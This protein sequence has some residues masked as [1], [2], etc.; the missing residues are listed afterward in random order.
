MFFYWQLH[1]TINSA[2]AWKQ[3]SKVSS[4]NSDLVGAG[5]LETM[6]MVSSCSTACTYSDLCLEARRIWSW[7]EIPYG[8]CLHWVAW[9][10]FHPAVFLIAETCGNSHANPYVWQKTIE[11]RQNPL[12]VPLMIIQCVYIYIYIHICVYILYIYIYIYMYIYV[13]VYIYMCVYTY[14]HIL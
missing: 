1:Q 9:C 7:I 4:Y 6:F 13:C 8:V 10:T 12:N 14:F 5:N 3:L 11:H 2:E